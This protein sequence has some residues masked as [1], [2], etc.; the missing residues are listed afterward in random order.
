MVKRTSI[1]QYYLQ[2]ENQAINTLLNYFDWNEEKFS[3]IHRRAEALVRNVRQQKSSWFDALLSQYSLATDEGLAMMCL[4]EALLR[5]PDKT[6]ADRLIRDKIGHANWEK[7]AGKSNSFLINMLTRLLMLTARCTNTGGLIKTLS[8]PLIRAGM[9]RTMK[10]LGEQFVM[11]E[12]IATAVSRAQKNEKIGYRYSYDMLGEAARTQQ[13]ADF[14]FQAYAQAIQVIG[15]HKENQELLNRPNISVKLSALF[16]SYTF[17][18]HE[19]IVA[20]LVPKLLILAQQAAA[21]NIGLTVDAEEASVLE[22]SLDI[23]EQVFSHESL[24][25]WN[26]LGLA[27]QAYQKRAFYVLDWLI[28]LARKYQKRWMIRLVKGAYWDS[29]IKMAQVL[30][31]EGYPVFTRKESTDVSY[32]AC[33]K[34]MLAA[35][36][37]VYG[38]FATHNAYSVAAVMEMVGGLKE[39]VDYEFQCLHGMG[40]ALYDQLVGEKKQNI[41]CRIYAPVGNHRELLPYLVRRLLENGAN[42]SFVN[43]VRDPKIPLEYLVQ[44]P[45][46]VMIDL[47]NRMNTRIPL[48]RD[49]FCLRKNSMG[50]NLS[51]PMM[52]EKFLNSLEKK[53]KQYNLDLNLAESNAQEIQK[54][55]AQAHQFC[56]DWDKVAVE[57]RAEYLEKTADLL[58]LRSDDFSAVLIKE[59]GKTIIDA[60]AEVREAVDFCRYYAEQ[61]RK[62]FQPQVMPGPTGE[63]NELTLHGRGTILCISPWNF[64]LA[65]FLGQITAALVAGNTVIAKPA[66]QTPF[67]AEMAIAL[68]YEAGVPKQALHLLVGKGETVGAQLVA[69]DCI[70]GVM[71]TG[72]TDTARLINQRLA[73]RA[74]AIIPFIAET[75]GQNTMIVD[76]SA[77]LDQV[78]VD[79]LNSA[80]GS[81]GQR[82]SALRVLFIQEEI[83]EKFLVSLKGAMAELVVG[84]PAQ[85]S[86]DVGPVID[87]AALSMLKAHLEKM[88]KTAKLIYQ[89]ELPE[90]LKNNQ[91]GY[92]FGPCAFEIDRL[93]QL[94]REIFGPFLHV[95][96]YKSSE[97]DQVLEHISQ[98]GYG[99]TQGIH[100]RISDSIDYMK[101]K[102]PVGNLYVNRNMIGA[103]VGVQ[104]FG[105]EGLSGTGP[106][107]GGPHYLYRLAVERT[108][109]INMA[110]AGGN[111]ALLTDLEC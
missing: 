40:N 63:Y 59:A 41:P 91:Q 93:P 8:S 4:A 106:K 1:H 46:K 57:K 70:K 28:D 16:P 83:K 25:H 95:I 3:Y 94:D 67:I 109:T 18:K 64:P 27:V 65:I 39:K 111:T 17:L 92:F 2:D 19:K 74:G 90:H 96:S 55:V 42:T 58:E 33:A 99:L 5:I 105:G 53:F 15:A 23:L 50:L 66:E 34:K 12:T 98:T 69:D 86:T 103:V 107:A 102:L 71:F 77:L 73:Q 48:P 104:P 30:G 78:I 88:H 22:L 60:I 9:M 32:L 51:D 89:V 97:L 43:K 61:A 62:Q 20:I 82:C 85:L 110:A 37:A 68:L 6:T 100:S 56:A 36:D 11:G 45:I 80:F 72:S 84:D 87:E 38:M 75:G 7:Y 24:K 26:G 108:L 10:R 21:Y 14:Y 31:L 13:E 76:S 44:C 52:V 81:A 29:E 35:Q 101:N 54:A 49:M 47:E 79:V